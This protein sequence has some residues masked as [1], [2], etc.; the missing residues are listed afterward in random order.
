GARTMS[1]AL[2]RLQL[3][4]LDELLG[5]RDGRLGLGLISGHGLKAR[6]PVWVGDATKDLPEC[7]VTLVQLLAE[8]LRVMQPRPER[9][10]LLFAGQVT[11]LDGPA[12]PEAMKE[13]STIVDLPHGVDVRTLACLIVVHV[14]LLF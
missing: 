9:G 4:R 1:R 6:L 10:V 7:T 13:E 2:G 8:I 11:R 12:T 5:R 3:A 14:P